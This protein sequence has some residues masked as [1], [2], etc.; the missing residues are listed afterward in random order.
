M[1]R[2]YA[3]IRQPHWLDM[4]RDRLFTDFCRLIAL[5]SWS[6]TLLSLQLSILYSLTTLLGPLRGFS[7]VGSALSFK[8]VTGYCIDASSISTNF[9]DCMPLPLVVALMPH[10]EALWWIVVLCWR[11]VLS[12][13]T[14]TCVLACKWHGQLNQL[15]SGDGEWVAAH[16]R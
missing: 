13:W 4:I 9:T 15:P 16:Q 3:C 14:T 8:T 12:S 1:D 5:M 11:S 2:Y 6:L 10:P 7:S